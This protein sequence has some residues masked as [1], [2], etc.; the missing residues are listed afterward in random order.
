MYIVL[1]MQTNGNQT[2]T[3][4]NAYTSKNEAYQKFHL[5]LSSASVSSVEIHTA[6]ILNEFGMIEAR[7]SFDHRET[8]A[9]S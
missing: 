5:I 3:L 6:I 1:E 2:A 4:T 8:P 7:G 9:E